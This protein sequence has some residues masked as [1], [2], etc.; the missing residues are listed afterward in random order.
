MNR[1]LIIFCN[2]NKLSIKIKLAIKSKLKKIALLKKT[3]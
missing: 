2:S 1:Y 3:Q